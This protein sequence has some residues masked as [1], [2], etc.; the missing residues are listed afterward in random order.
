MNKFWITYLVL[1]LPFFI[2]NGILTGTGPD[3]PVVWYNNAENLQLRIL[4]IP[5][6]D[7]A[8]GMTLILWNIV[9]FEAFSKKRSLGCKT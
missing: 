8:Y 1:L 7:F 4:T 9:L 6:E 5:V 3:N 2:V